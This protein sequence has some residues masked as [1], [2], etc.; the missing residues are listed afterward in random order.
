[1]CGSPTDDTQ[2]STDF[3]IHPNLNSEDLN[4][5]DTKVKRGSK[6]KRQ[7][8]ELTLDILTKRRSTR[9]R[10]STHK[11]RLQKEIIPAVPFEPEVDYKKELIELLP[12]SMQKMQML[13]Q[14]AAKDNNGKPTNKNTANPE[15]PNIQIMYKDYTTEA[16]DVLEF[17]R[18]SLQENDGILD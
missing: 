11:K 13:K 18:N 8:V 4:S 7:P 16:K 9:V 12:H 1:L 3:E 6:R 17:L 14:L 5:E 10:T 2:S 15:I